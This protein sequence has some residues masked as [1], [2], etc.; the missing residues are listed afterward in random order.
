MKVNPLM[1][2]GESECS[3]V[4]GLNGRPFLASCPGAVSDHLCLVINTLGKQ[5]AVML[6]QRRIYYEL[7][8]KIGQDNSLATGHTVESGKCRDANTRQIIDI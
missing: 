4:R 8:I 3:V 6:G 1:G 5:D 7:V 2:H